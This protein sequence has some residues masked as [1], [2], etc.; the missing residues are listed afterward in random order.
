M[1]TE[2]CAGGQAPA[3]GPNGSRGG[4]SENLFRTALSRLYRGAGRQAHVEARAGRYIFHWWPSTDADPV[5][6]T[7]LEKNKI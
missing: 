2:T 6:Q 4:K 3:G 1:P 5:E 7:Y